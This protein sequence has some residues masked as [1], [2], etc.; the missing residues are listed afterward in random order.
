MDG[1]P[2]YTPRGFPQWA[3][4]LDIDTQ[5]PGNKGSTGGGDL[6]TCSGRVQVRD[7]GFYGSKM[8][9]FTIALYY[10]FI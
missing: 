6:C 3:G 5:K 8:I 1:V 9:G 4:F 7:A 10:K 2:Q